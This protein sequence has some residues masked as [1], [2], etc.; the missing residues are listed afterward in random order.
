[1]ISYLLPTRDRPDRLRQTLQALDRLPLEAHRGVGGAE[2]VVVDDA[3]GAPPELA[4][5]LP[6]GMPV[7]LVRLSRRRGAAARNAGVDIARGTWVVMLDDD[8]HPLDAGLVDVIA[9]AP[10][11]VAAIGAEIL[12]PDGRHEDGGLPEV[13]VGCGAALRRE[14]FLQV[15]GYD[16]DFDYYAEEYDFC[17]K[18]ILADWQII[19]DLRF[20]V[21]H[22]KSADGREMNR[23]LHNLVR[24]NGWIVRRYAPDAEYEAARRDLVE[25][26]SVIAAHEHAGRGFRRGLEELRVTLPGQPRRQMPRPL[27]DRFTGLAQV[28]AALAG[29]PLLRGARVAV[30]DEGKNA[31]VV[32]RVLADLGCGEVSDVQDAEVL[33]VGTL[34]PGPMLDASRRRADDGR[35]VILPWRPRGAGGGRPA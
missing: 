24:N 30:V 2:V 34:S 29:Q 23:I 22:H 10:A 26:Y 32:R 25:R 16:G 31:W 4:G 6:N 5:A 1:M 11:N 28:R 15:G 17:A 27:W 14:A 3:S 7:R 9:H 21:L 33:V 20:R 19:H 12:L 35:P 13:F 18:L 8:S